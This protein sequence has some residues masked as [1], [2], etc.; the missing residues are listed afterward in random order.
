MDD[1][2]N[3]IGKLQH[4]KVANLLTRYVSW[5]R[6]VAEARRS[7]APRPKVPEIG[8]ISINLDLTTACN[9]R[10][11]HCIDWDLLNVKARHRENEIRQ[12][13]VELRRRGLESVILIGG[14]E[15]TLYPHFEEMISFIKSLGLQV[16]IVSNGSRCDRLVQVAPD[17][18]KGDWIRLSLDAGSNSLFRAMHKPVNESINLDSICGHVPAIRAANP[19]ISIGYSFIVVWDGTTRGDSSIHE[20]IREI[21]DAARRAKRSGFHYITYKA[22]LERWQDGS[23]VMAPKTCTRAVDDVLYEIRAELAKAHALEDETFSVKESTNIRALNDRS[24]AD[25]KQQPH[26][27]HMQIL[28]QV[29]TPLGIF[30]CPAHRGVEWA[31]IGDKNGYADFQRTAAITEATADML[32]TFD[33]QCRCA[34]VTC[35]YNSTNWW[36]EDLIEGRAVLPDGLEPSWEDFFL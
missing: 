24:W 17:L 20:N 29:L 12:S 23:E 9:F 1:I 18:A 15:P 10:C 16:A 27:C 4:P 14:G 30:N 31:R 11:D 22:V 26:T 35:I 25:L 7:G 5:R 21:V 8:P 28:R 33:A 36:L 34:E 32:D 13:L 19:D 3:F 6:L 2:H